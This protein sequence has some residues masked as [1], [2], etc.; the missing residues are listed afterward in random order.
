MNKR[1]YPFIAFISILSLFFNSIP[2]SASS[3]FL[4]Q[5][6]QTAEDKAQDLIN[7]LTTPEKIGQLFLVSF[8]GASAEP[9]T[10]IY[11][12]I[13]NDHIGGV[14]LSAANDN[15]SQSDN[16]LENVAGL[17][18]QLQNIGWEQSQTP[19]T[20]TST[21][22]PVPPANFIPLF[23]GISQ[24]GGGAP[25]DQLLSGLTPLPDAM[26]I[27]ATWSPKLSQQVGFVLGKE[28]SSLGFNLLLG[29][30]LDV[31]ETPRQEGAIDLGTRS[32]GG[33]PFWVS[34]LGSSYIQGVHEGSSGKIA[35]VAK[36]FPG[37]GGS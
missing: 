28:L 31:L 32:F 6:P 10:P 17:T 30:A 1:I 29:P 11:T 2:S 3:I 25:N 22:T 21:T 35:V 37:N 15:F 14:I 4:N 27:G 26:A 24:E 5:F 34:T 33:D 12:L 8:K 20:T 16:L 36:N 9:G 23:I 7:Q 13:T 18:S 19:I